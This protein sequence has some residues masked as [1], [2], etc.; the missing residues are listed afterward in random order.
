VWRVGAIGRKPGHLLRIACLAWVT[1]AAASGQVNWERAVYYDASYPSTFTQ[2]I[3]VR[4]VLASDGYTVLDAV[5]L[6]SWMDDRIADGL[7]S[8]VVFSRDVAPDTVAEIQSPACTLRQYLDAGGKIVWYADIPLYYQGHADG[9]LTVWFNDGSSAILGFN[10]AAAAWDVDQNVTFTADGTAWGLTETWASIRP[11]FPSGNRV[12]AND[13]NFAASAWVRHYLAGDTYRGFVRIYD[14]P[15]TPNIDDLRRVAEYPNPVTPL[16]AEN[17]D[18]AQDDIVCAFFYPWYGTPQTSGAWRHWQEGGHAPP[19]TWGAN[20]VPNFPDATWNPATQLYDSNAVDVQRWQDRDMARAGLDIA[21]SSWWG[22]G[23]FS[24]Q[25]FAKAIYTCKSVQW[26]IYY[27]LDSAGDPSAQAI[28]SDIKY[29]LD[30]YTQYRNYARIDGKW[31]VMVYAVRDVDAS[32]RW[33]QAKSLLAADGYDVYL[34]AFGDTSPTVAP[35][36]WDAVHIYGP[37]SRKTLTTSLA[38]VD[39]SHSISPGFWRWHDPPAL[40][41]DFNDFNAKLVDIDAERGQS[42]FILV[43][44]WNE[45]HEGSSIEPGREVVHDDLGFTPTGNDYGHDYVDAVAATAHGMRWVS[46]GHRPNALPMRLEA[47]TM[48]W[49]PGTTAD[50]PERWRLVQDDARI[51]G[52]LE[53][54]DAVQTIGISVRARAVQVG[55]SAG[56]PDL[57]LWWDDAPVATWTVE[58]LA[59]QTY[60]TTIDTVPGVHKIELGLADDP[61]GAL[62]VDLSVD[63]VQIVAVSANA[64]AVSRSALTL[65]ALLLAVAGYIA[66][67]RH[68]EIA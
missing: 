11:T 57:V 29:V 41:R 17:T 16:L 20:Y 28:Y 44:T 66:I 50:G 7:P 54:S 18:E 10:A 40:V 60:C 24:D 49:E 23:S 36:P 63:Y 64:P 13:V 59:D 31:L 25:A 27:E 1:A 68:R 37:T 67:R 53:W 48:V 15:G 46:S 26:C 39:D 58:T 9:T 14:R 47:E 21:V 4:D 3:W 45:W 33:R 38:A 2:G 56:W 55:P 12:L 30:N 52:S 34:N 19:S 62:D 42:R 43:E 35:D 32:D 22:Q 5:A 65:M 51:G 6:K 61:G 8:V